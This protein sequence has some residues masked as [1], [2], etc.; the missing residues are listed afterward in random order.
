MQP[1]DHA[2]GDVAGRKDVGELGNPHEGVDQDAPQAIPLDGN[3][4][5]S[6]LARMPAHQTTVCVG[7]ISPEL[8]R[9]PAASIASTRTPRRVS[10]PS[11]DSAS[12]ITGRARS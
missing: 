6:G 5:A 10:T 4:A 11:A 12:L 9:T 3:V 7:M 8:R 1:V 2:R